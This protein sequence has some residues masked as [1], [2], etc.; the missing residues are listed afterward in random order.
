[1]LSG[2]LHHSNVLVMANGDTQ[3]LQKMGFGARRLHGI[4]AA[5]EFP[6]LRGF[7]PAPAPATAP[8]PA[9][10]SVFASASASAGTAA[11]VMPSPA[12]VHANTPVGAT[13]V[14]A[15]LGNTQSTVTTAVPAPAPLLLLDEE[16]GVRMRSEDRGSSQLFL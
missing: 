7:A 1:M 4:G 13:P 8:N 11:L 10:A 16:V 6:A 15:S 9:P 12:A 2:V 3:Q 5:E 14:G